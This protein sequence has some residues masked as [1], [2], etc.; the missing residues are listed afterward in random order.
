MFS[1]PQ[2]Q[3]VVDKLLAGENLSSG[4]VQIDSFDQNTKLLLSAILE[5]LAQFRDR[6]GDDRARYLRD[7]YRAMTEEDRNAA[8]GTPEIGSIG[9]KAEILEHG[10]YRLEK[11]ICESFRGLA[12]PGESV[13]F[14][15]SGQSN[16]IYGPN[17]SGKT[18]L[19]GSIIWLFTGEAVSDAIEPAGSAS[20]YTHSEDG[21]ALPKKTTDWHINVT[22]PEEE[23][24]K[25]TAQECS[26]TA[27]LSN[28]SS[29]LYIRR[30]LITGLEASV[31][32][33]ASWDSCLD[34]S[35]FGIGPLD[36]Q[37]SLKAPTA[38][39]RFTVENA[40]DSAHVLGLLLGYDELIELGVLIDNIGR[41][42]TTLEG[43]E[44]R[45]AL[46]ARES[47]RSEIDRLL[48]RLPEGYSESVELQGIREAQEVDS[49]HIEAAQQF[50]RDQVARSE[51]ELAE[52]VGLRPEDISETSSLTAA[53]QG[54]LF[55]L[56]KN[57][58]TSFSGLNAVE[59]S[60]ILALD[61]DSSVEEQLAE[62]ASEFDSFI[63]S[64]IH[65]IDE[66]F[67]WWTQEEKSKGRA[68]LLLKASS[69]FDEKT[70][71]CPVC[72]RPI[73]ELSL[74]NELVKLRSM[75]K[76]LL[77]SVEDFFRGL[78]E[79]LNTIIPAE[80]RSLASSVPQTRILADWSKLKR[81]SIDAVFTPVVKQFDTR[82]SEI[83]ERARL[84]QM[85]EFSL[86]PE[87]AAPLFHKLGER[88]KN[89]VDSTRLSL[90]I[91]NWSNAHLSAV[92][93]ELDAAV[94]A[95]SSDSSLSL[96]ATLAKGKEAADAI[97]PLVEAREQLRQ[98]GKSHKELT[99][100]ED[101]VK[102][103]R[104][105]KPQVEA[106]KRIK[107]YAESKI[108]VAFGEI[109]DITLENWK[110][111]Y[112]EEPSGFQPSR[113]HSRKGKNAKVLSFLTNGKS[114][115][116][117]EFF[118]NA[119]LQR[120]IALSFF[121]ALLEKHPRGLSFVVMDDPIL[122]LDDDHRERWSSDILKPRMRGCQFVIA[123]HQQHFYSNC[124]DD[125][126]GEKVCELNRR[127]WPRKISWKPGGRLV[128]ARE[129]LKH[130]FRAVPNL[131][132]Q[133]CE[134]LIATLES[135]A[136]G[137]FEPKGELG[138]AML[139][140]KGLSENEELSKGYKD[141]ICDF[142]LGN[143][144]KQV[145][146][147]GSHARTQPNVTESMI[148]DCLNDLS[149]C[150][151][152]FQKEIKRLERVY[153]Q[154]RRQCIVQT[155]TVPFKRPSV[156]WES[157]LEIECFGVAA[158]KNE[159]WEVNTTDEVTNWLVSPGFAVL[160]V[161]SS[162]E[163]VARPGQWAILSQSDELAR[164]GD[165]VAVAC[166]NGERFLR[167]IWSDGD[168]WILHSINPV[169]G[170]PG[171]RV[172]KRE[173]SCRRVIGI[174]YEP[175]RPSRLRKNSTIAEWCPRNDFPENWSGNC[176]IVSVVGESL[177]PIAR[178]GQHVLVDRTVA[179][180]HMSVSNGDLAVV[181]SQA[182]DIGRVIKRI[183]HHD[184]K[185]ILVSPNPVDPHPPLVLTKQDL[186]HAK[187]W[188]VRGILFEA[189]EL[190]S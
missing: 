5:N 80:I 13:E 60:D 41:N 116:P 79:E 152:L 84:P 25:D 128:Q 162:L 77:Q 168:H 166:E 49:S 63:K 38:F 138:S 61:K 144:V 17:G 98:I 175:F 12:P 156:G 18:S 181:D 22:L 185:C 147:P 92:M 190:M 170:L 160:V 182:E 66:R 165:L 54:A 23:V 47:L 169:E 97:T 68:G 45:A 150:D 153:E 55:E 146:N 40:P 105:I 46:E 7:C 39:G 90:G 124:R 75:D 184:G 107:A 35:V 103:L 189:T 76:R 174:L 148:L 157:S 117:A 72:V 179:K 4:V 88:L 137:P 52:L 108:E 130:D 58:R 104:E 154:S 132:R 15:F 106:I 99:K 172:P 111:L 100:R 133:Y 14:E 159:Y 178:R 143:R 9:E 24:S 164:D 31:D 34:L 11:V 115:V 131:M 44:A 112:P 122:S 36:L 29:K 113:L 3:A 70:L 1:S 67:Q 167:R 21:E 81:D 121:F 30:N 127:P 135:F 129:M 89:S 8:H 158:A 56:G 33:G 2:S 32:E 16:L 53:L 183:Y 59:S 161:G 94:S 91:L 134:S 57:I 187:F 10:Q 186:Q 141:K 102:V 101:D 136:S 62:I 69:Y 114:E 120:A 163:P 155:A 119:G 125:F 82:I 140:Y 6:S 83:A 19:L 149:Q 173:A 43:K 96:F 142:L 37:L 27:V 48:E 20:I 109:R 95:T 177:D 188:T 110:K 126:S 93:D 85:D 51:A 65:R 118:A 180:S 145:L 71:A 171:I 151:K 74:V 64:S 50:F 78:E 73:D 139:A 42:R 28:S 86:L 87:E 176:A 123:T 26:V